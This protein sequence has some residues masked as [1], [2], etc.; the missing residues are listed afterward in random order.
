MRFAVL[1]TVPPGFCR[2][3]HV[4]APGG[5][6]ADLAELRRDVLPAAG[7][8]PTHMEAIQGFADWRARGISPVLGLTMWY[9]ETCQTSTGAFLRTDDAPEPSI[10]VAIRY[11]QLAGQLSISRL[12]CDAVDLAARWLEA[13]IEDDGALYMPASGAL[14]FG[15]MARAIRSLTVVS[16]TDKPTEPICRLAT[17]L[18]SATIGD[19][20]WP[21]YPGGDPSTGA[22]SLALVAI[23]TAPRAFDREPDLTWLLEAA[24]PDGGWGEYIGSPSKVDNTFWAYRGTGSAGQDHAEVVGRW[25]NQCPLSSDYEQAMATRLNIA[26]GTPIHNEQLTDLALDTMASDADRYAET[27]LYSVALAEALTL[28]QTQEPTAAG[29]PDEDRDALLSIAG[30]YRAI[31]TEAPDV[32]EKFEASFADSFRIAAVAEQLCGLAPFGDNSDVGVQAT[33]P[34]DAPDLPLE[35]MAAIDAAVPP[36]VDLSFTSIRHD[37]RDNGY[38][39]VAAVPDDWASSFFSSSEWHSREKFGFFTEL[40]MAAAC[41]GLCEPRDWEADLRDVSD[42]SPFRFD[43]EQGASISLDEE[44]T[45]PAGRLMVIAPPLDRCGSN[46]PDR[47]QE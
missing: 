42:S 5:R 29:A 13:Q 26:L 33:W 47:R 4:L 40:V 1:N 30:Y 11:L 28:E 39:V 34:D 23:A 31:A 21:T 45:E 44:L 36:G 19:S 9:F 15:M 20:V 3:M 25:L 2:K 12:E 37:L 18:S 32:L 14:D 46:E 41:N 35:Q 16:P 8:S 10:G 7:L 43:T 6:L 27:A 17:R 22:T 38:P 24:N